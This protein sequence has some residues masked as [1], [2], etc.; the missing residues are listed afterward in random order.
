MDPSP[1]S[2]LT[3]LPR[4]PF[5]KATRKPHS[6]RIMP[7]WLPTTVYVYVCVCVYAWMHVCMCVHVPAYTFIVRLL[8]T[9][10]LHPYL[11]NVSNDTIFERRNCRFLTILPTW[12]AL[13]CASFQQHCEC[14]CTIKTRGLEGQN[15][16]FWPSWP[17]GGARC[18]APP[19]P[20]CCKH[21][22]VVTHMHPGKVH[23]HMHVINNMC[24]WI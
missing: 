8:S 12:R 4:T 7:G 23:R 16:H 19:A 22:K 14:T 6:A 1:D 24:S 11:E 15:S 2:P 20:L 10:P 17:L 21:T 9:A 18:C 13:S 3:P 5:A